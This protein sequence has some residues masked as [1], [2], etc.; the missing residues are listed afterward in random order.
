MT[1]ARCYKNLIFNI[2]CVFEDKILSGGNNWLKN[3]TYC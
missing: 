3:K 1:N 2:I